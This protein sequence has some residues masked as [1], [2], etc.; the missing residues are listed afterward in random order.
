MTV[1]DPSST[2]PG[3]DVGVWTLRGARDG[4]RKSLILGSNMGY[5]GA[6]VRVSFAQ[7]LGASAS[8]NAESGGATSGLGRGAVSVLGSEL[9]ANLASDKR[10]LWFGPVGSGG[11][12]VEW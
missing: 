7:V 3:V 6:G 2:G 4:K 12:V 1:P 8:T 5:G 9:G 11:W 10:S